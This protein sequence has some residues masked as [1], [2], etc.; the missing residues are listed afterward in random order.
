ME[1]AKPNAAYEGL[2]NQIS[3]AY[4]QGQRQA[5]IAVNS[6]LLDTYW[7]VGQ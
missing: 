7:K 4:V 3:E 5:V 6:H 2:V 1:I